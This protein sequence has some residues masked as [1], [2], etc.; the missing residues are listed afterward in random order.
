[1]FT[2]PDKAYNVLKWVVM[3]VLPACATL[4]TTLS[5]LWGFPFTEQITGTITAVAVFMG[6]ILMISSRNYKKLNSADE[7]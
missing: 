7:A 4:Y 1:M 3:I 6:A 2:I 5:G